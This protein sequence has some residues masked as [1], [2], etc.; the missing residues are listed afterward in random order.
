MHYEE[1]KPVIQ[2]NAL[3]REFV[4]A[5]ERIRFN[6]FGTP[7]REWPRCPKCDEDELFGGDLGGFNEIR[8]YRCRLRLIVK[9]QPVAT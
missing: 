3:P 9:Q 4:E 6:E 5:M 1:G 2:R 8:C 7:D